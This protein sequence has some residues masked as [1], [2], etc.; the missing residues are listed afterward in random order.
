MDGEAGRTFNPLETRGRPEGDMDRGGSVTADE[1]GGFDDWGLLIEVG[2]LIAE[3]FVVSLVSGRGIRRS[4]SSS[5]V[6]SLGE[7]VPTIVQ[8][9]SPTKIYPSL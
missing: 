1:A 5:C 4:L 8:I 6:L 7:S 3:G 9:L 2:G